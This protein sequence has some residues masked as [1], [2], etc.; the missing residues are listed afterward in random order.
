MVWRVCLS[1][2]V[3][4]G[5]RVIVGRIVAAGALI[6][7]E[8]YWEKAA[9]SIPT[10]PAPVGMWLDFFLDATDTK[11]ANHVSGQI[12]GLL[13]LAGRV[14]VGIRPILAHARFL[15]NIFNAVLVISGTGAIIWH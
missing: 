3:V 6:Q 2:L 7:F 4:H 14:A 11:L 8:Q 10:A 13:W 12:L 9:R 5:L 1:F 15:I